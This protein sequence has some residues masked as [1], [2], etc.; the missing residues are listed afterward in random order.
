M[1]ET[2]LAH[3]LAELQ[4]L[5]LLLRV[6]AWRS[7]QGRAET[8]ELAAFY[9]ADA[10]ADALLDKA[11]GAP[12]WAGVT[13]PPDMRAS[14][15]AELDE[16]ARD[17]TEHAAESLRL[18]VPLRLA[19]LAGL[20]GLSA[21]DRDVIVLCLAPELDRA[22]ERLYA[23]LHDDVTR[24][25]PS[26][27]LALHLFCPDLQAKVAA[28]ARFSP[29]G[30]L[31]R[32]HLVQL[33]EEPGQ[34][35]ASWPAQA[36][37]LDPRVASF[38]L[39]GDEIDDRLQSC[40]RVV[41]TAAGLDDLVLPAALRGQLSRLAAHARTAGPAADDAG[42]VLYLQGPNGAG[43]QAAAAAFG[44]ALGRPLLVVAGK[45][46]GTSTLEELAAVARLADREAGS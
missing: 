28:R 43:Q 18:G 5:D 6:Q 29:A 23:Y 41:S 33:S 15:Q 12:A 45:R 39:G 19:R 21:L 26:I 31:L 20:F 11:I 17:I 14:V 1:Y 25:L 40:A 44:Q 16:L 7:R 42:I 9:I 37:R 35:P 36:V 8:G 13:L 10:E 30:P 27:E 3:I 32:H 4:R 34:G 46:L 2:S 38:L 22:Y 24:R